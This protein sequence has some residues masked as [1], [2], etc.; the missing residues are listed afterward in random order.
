MQVRKAFHLL[1]LVFR[2]VF[3]QVFQCTRPRHSM[4]ESR[5]LSVIVMLLSSIVVELVILFRVPDSADFFLFFQCDFLRLK[6]DHVQN[7][8]I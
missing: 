6:L 3:V 8:Y 2:D 7:I 5:C 4:Q 1:Q